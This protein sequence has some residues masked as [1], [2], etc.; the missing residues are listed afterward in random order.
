MDT[1]VS[2]RATHQDCPVLMHLDRHF[3]AKPHEAFDQQRFV[4]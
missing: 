3:D 2:V 1:K 4:G